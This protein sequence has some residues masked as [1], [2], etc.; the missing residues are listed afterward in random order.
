M[1]KI[2]V[3]YI[4]GQ[5]GRKFYVSKTKTGLMKQIANYC[6]YWW[7]EYMSGVKEPKTNLSIIHKFFDLKYGAGYREFFV[8]DNVEV[9]D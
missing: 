4:D 3:G 9:I 8:W 1:M 7:K 5:N 6:H 2:Y